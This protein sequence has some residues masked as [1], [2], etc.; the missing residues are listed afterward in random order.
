MPV[1]LK[2]TETQHLYFNL[3]SI[4]MGFKKTLKLFCLFEACM[5]EESSSYYGVLKTNQSS[6]NR[7]QLP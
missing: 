4:G 5:A 1:A 2:E 3:C 6:S 7:A